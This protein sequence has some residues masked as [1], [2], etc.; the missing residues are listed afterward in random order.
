MNRKIFITVQFLHKCTFIDTHKY[1]LVILHN[2]TNTQRMRRHMITIAVTNQKG[3]VGKT[4][5]S[6]NI[7]QILSSQYKFKVL[8]IDND[9]QG[10][11]TSSFI[12]DPSKLEAHILDAYE[13][14]EVRPEKI[15]SNLH[16]LGSSITLAP[17]P[18]KS[19]YVIFKLRES[20]ENLYN[21]SNVYKYDFVIIDCLP[22][23]G[24]LHLAAL[25]AANYAL[26]PV[27]PAPYSLTGMKDLFDIIDKTK[28][29]INPSLKIL[30]IVLN[31]VDGRMPI[32]QRE[33]EGALREAYKD[34]VF[35]AKINKR[36]KIEES[37]AFQKSIT[38]YDPKG[39]SSKEF[40]CF[41]K[42]L[43][44]RLNKKRKNRISKNERI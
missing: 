31:H 1:T 18:E 28:K 24:H 9:P 5:I 8:A 36:I 10:N 20:L 37:P 33:M 16:F 27:K 3:G 23:F 38:K 7:A 39:P 12:E 25:T 30:G 35:E 42:E 2:C 6:F 26:I 19:F 34:L 4:T 21:S 41:T 15:S 44:R 17:V 43:L 13:G 29:H 22:S 40:M 11:L 14:R 32:L